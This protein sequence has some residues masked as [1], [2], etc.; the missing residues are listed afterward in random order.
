MI[1][2]YLR[3]EFHVLFFTINKKETRTEEISFNLKI[4]KRAVRETIK[5]INEHFEELMKI[6]DFVV[7]SRNGNIK[8]REEYWDCAISLAYTLK[9]LLLKK[10]I[11]F[12]YMD[13]LQLTRQ[14]N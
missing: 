11:A 4:S 5:T 14:K 12:N 3:R 9:L 2:N 8:I 6:T 1:P 13:R 10:N 7:S